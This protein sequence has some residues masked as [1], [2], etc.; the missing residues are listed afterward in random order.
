MHLN[1]TYILRKFFFNSAYINELN[2]QK[3]VYS[4]FRGLSVKPDLPCPDLPGPSI[5]Q[6]SILSPKNKI[7]VWINVKFIR[8]TVLLD[9]PGLLPSPREYISGFLLYNPINIIDNGICFPAQSRIAGYAIDEIGSAA[10]QPN[11]ND[12]IILEGYTNSFRLVCLGSPNRLIN[13]SLNWKI[14]ACNNCMKYCGTWWKMIIALCYPNNIF[15][16]WTNHYLRYTNYIT[17]DNDGKFPI[18]KVPYA[19]LTAF[20]THD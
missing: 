13:N 18:I 6:A 4:Y 20:S 15:M 14:G 5:C 16:F 1:G 2:R 11:C 9:L 3:Y 10:W 12:M 7:Y 17:T 19:K 8:F